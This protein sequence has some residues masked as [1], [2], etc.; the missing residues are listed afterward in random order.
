MWAGY[1]TNEMENQFKHY[2]T[3]QEDGVYVEFHRI[4]TD[5]QNLFLDEAYREEDTKRYNAWLRGDWCYV[6]IQAE[7]CISVVEDG[8]AT[9]YSIKSA[10]LWGIE[11][12]AGEEY[13]AMVFKEECEILKEH[14]KKFS[15]F[16]EKSKGRR[17]EVM[18]EIKYQISTHFLSAIFNDD[19]TGLEDKEVKHLKQWL[20]QQADTLPANHFHH[21]ADLDSGY[22]FARCEITGM[23]SNVADVAL[24][25]SLKEGSEK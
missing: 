9:L 7:A 25:Y 13:F 14:L 5:D 18:Q 15:E 20:K 6:G 11:S 17:S 22:D 2:D 10:G 21:W 4:V 24:V 12:D 16:V 3:K 1:E 8:T 19:Y 23:L